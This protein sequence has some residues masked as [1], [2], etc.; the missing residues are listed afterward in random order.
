MYLKT[1]RS[2]GMGDALTDCMASAMTTQEGY[3]PNFAANNNP[4]NIVYIGP[5][6]NGQTGVTR[7]A[8][9]FARFS[10]PA[11]GQAALYNQIQGQI[12][13][14]QNL[15]QFFNQ[16]APPNTVNAAG[17]VQTSAATQAYISN[18]ASACGLDTSTPLN[19]IQAQYSGPGSYSPSGS[20][21][22]DSS[23]S[24]DSSPSFDLSSLIPGFDASQSYNVGGLVLSG[25]DLLLLGGALV[26]GL[27]ISAML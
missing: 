3:N 23:S 10:S 4:G 5:T 13:R 1:T 22:S 9:G 7:G 6:Q 15:I 19:Q 18:V 25:S 26:L 2:G 12:S 27:V 24:S 16:Y 14:G 17:G 11:S 21:F 8:G 20:S